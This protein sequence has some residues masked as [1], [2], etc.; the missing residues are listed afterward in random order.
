MLNYTTEAS[1]IV[2]KVFFFFNI[3]LPTRDGKILHLSPMTTLSWIKFISFANCDQR[4]H[5]KEPDPGASLVVQ[6]LRICL[7]MQGTRVQ[8]LV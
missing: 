3:D 4:W 2:S 6:W 5:F 1:A 8:A 7:P